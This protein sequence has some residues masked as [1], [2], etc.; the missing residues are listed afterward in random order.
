M[1]ERKEYSC[2]LLVSLIDLKTMEYWML[3]TV[4]NSVG[5]GDDNLY[6]DGKYDD[7]VGDRSSR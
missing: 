1:V 5:L 2:I 7:D 4:F 3:I 6:K